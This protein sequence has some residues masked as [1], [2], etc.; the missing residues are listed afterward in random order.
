[1][2]QSL[3]DCCYCLSRFSFWLARASV[4]ALWINLLVQEQFEANVQPA[5]SSSGQMKMIGGPDWA[6][7]PPI[8]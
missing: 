8:E 5:Y 7:G 2:L 1:M 3:V 6:H 4:A